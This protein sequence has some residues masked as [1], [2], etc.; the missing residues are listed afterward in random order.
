MQDY[1][2]AYNQTPERK[3][4]MQDYRIRKYGMSVDQYKSLLSSQK[5]RC[6][7]CNNEFGKEFPPNIDHCHKLGHVRAILCG[8]CNQAEGL[9]RKA[10]GPDAC[11]AL[12]RYMIANFK[13]Y[14]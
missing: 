6:E 11:F 8:P 2:K 9:L 13:S 3:A 10:G 12:Y 1:N 4:Y 7:V 14:V 5:N